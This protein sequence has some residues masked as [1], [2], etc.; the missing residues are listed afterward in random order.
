MMKIAQFKTERQKRQRSH[1]NPLCTN[2]WECL[3]FPSYPSRL[4][5]PLEIKEFTKTK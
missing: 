3:S 2:E 1:S 5:F 4:I